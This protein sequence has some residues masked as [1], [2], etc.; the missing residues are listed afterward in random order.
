MSVSKK[1]SISIPTRM[2]IMEVPVMK[3]ITL[4]FASMHPPSKKN[5]PQTEVVGLARIDVGN[6]T[7]AGSI[8]KKKNP[9]NHLKIQLPVQPKLKP[10]VLSLEKKW[11]ANRRRNVITSVLPC[12]Y[13]TIYLPIKMAHLYHCKQVYL[14]AAN[15]LIMS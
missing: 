15:D 5:D 14:T 9:N 13:S 11:P 10:Q 12:N 8:E 6:G 4:I 1:Q 7:S 2:M 3:M